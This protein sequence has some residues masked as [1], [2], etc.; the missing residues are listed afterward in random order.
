MASL[1]VEQALK[2]PRHEVGEALLTVPEDQWFDRKSFRIRP[3]ELGDW[4]IGFANAEGGVLAVGLHDGRV[5]G[6]D[7]DEAHRNAL[8]Q[9]FL[10]FTE[11]PVKAATELVPCMRSDGGPDHLLVVRIAVTDIVHANRRDE[12][13]LRV[14]DEN[15]RMTFTQRQELLYDKGQATF[16]S[17]RVEGADLSDID[18][19]A[20]DDYAR[21]LEATNPSGMLRARGLA[22]DDGPTVAGLLLFGRDPQRF[23]P[24][25]FVRVL[26]YRGRERGTGARQQ[27]AG[28]WK[29]AGPIPRQLDDARRRIAEV[30]PARRALRDTGRFGDV[31][32]VPP[33]AWL[34]GVVNAVVHRSYGLAGDHVR[35]DV[36]DDRIEVASPGRAP[37]LVDLT[38]PL[39]STRFARN[40]RVARVCADLGFGQELGEGLRRMVEEMRRAG[41][42]DPLFRQTAGS[43]HL[44]LSAQPLRGERLPDEARIILDA[45]RQ[46]DRL[47]TS[48]IAE[49]VG[50]S[51]P[52]TI[53]RLRALREAGLISWVGKSA[54]DPRAYWTLPRS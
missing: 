47:R 36:F 14:G 40:P 16:E 38:D 8:R 21:R 25:A 24:E 9:A 19:S 46:V 26:R 42:A 43:V 31:P 30:Q 15:R 13:F 54:R 28:D 10:D 53:A 12:V 7:R 2:R 37:G 52:A 33:S 50:L 39:N 6:T 34:E 18:A 41:L 32:L 22:L 29:I 3:R 44:T 4:L 49:L 1:A 20:V 17:R 48:E 35:V 11:R 45:L 23:L 5:E 51:R 27:L